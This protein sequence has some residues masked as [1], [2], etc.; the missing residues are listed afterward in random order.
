M[1]H[2]IERWQV[3]QTLDEISKSP[4]RVF[5]AKVIRRSPLY[6]RYPPRNMTEN[7]ALARVGDHVPIGC[8]EW[9]NPNVVFGPDGKLYDLTS[10]RI[11][12]RRGDKIVL[13]EAGET[14]TISIKN[15][16]REKGNQSKHAPPVT[17]KGL[18]YDP[19]KHDLFP[20]AGFYNDQLKSQPNGE[21][22]IGRF[23][24]WR[25]YTQVCMRGILEFNALND[26]WIVITPPQT[27]PIEYP[28]EELE[29][30]SKRFA[31]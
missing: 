3:K 26:T 8:D 6:L 9:G 25:P 20:L 29:T 13:Q 31:I 24:Q 21:R 12:R 16:D 23:G 1:I 22:R 30:E 5:T 11:N 28:T 4:W 10:S 15:Y 18:N 17:G 19:L 7:G 2:R 14:R 27:E